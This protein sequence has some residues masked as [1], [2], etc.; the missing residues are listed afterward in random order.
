MEHCNFEFWILVSFESWWCHLGLPKEGRF[1][2]EE[3]DFLEGH[4]FEEVGRVVGTW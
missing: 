2:E 3:E 1:G 4:N